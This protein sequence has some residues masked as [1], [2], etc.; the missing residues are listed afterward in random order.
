MN[1]GGGVAYRI[2]SPEL[3]AVRNELRHDLQGLL[4]AQDSAGWRPHVT[5][6]NKV[7]PKV[8]R[9][10]LAKLERGFSPRPLAVSGLGL[11]RYLDGPWEKIATY[12]FRGVS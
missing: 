4:T 7:T 5:I 12:P 1:L 2:E 8:A 9:E 3:D 11:Q 10:L 6:Q